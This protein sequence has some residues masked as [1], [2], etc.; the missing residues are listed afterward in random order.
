MALAARRGFDD[1]LADRDDRVVVVAAV[2]VAA[3]PALTRPALRGA[4]FG[5]RDFEAGAFRAG[6]FVAT[7]FA[8]VVVRA[9]LRWGVFAVLRLRGV[10]REVTLALAPLVGLRA[11]RLA[12]VGRAV[13]VTV[14]ANARRLARA[15]R[16]G[17]VALRAGE[18]AGRR[19]T[20]PVAALRVLLVDADREAMIPPRAP[21]AGREGVRADP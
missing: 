15:G 10:G 3:F 18:V 1:D 17:V 19:R 4:V 2:A 9:P 12:P 6:A 11:L 16:L 5:A 14:S 20:V 7:F 8:V 13:G 21:G